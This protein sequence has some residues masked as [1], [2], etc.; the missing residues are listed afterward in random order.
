MQLPIVIPN[1]F[2]CYLAGEL[3]SNGEITGSGLFT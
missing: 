3:L 2:V 1:L